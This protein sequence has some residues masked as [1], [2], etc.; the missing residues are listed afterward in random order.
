[1]R[2]RRMLLPTLLAVSGLAAATALPPGLSSS[3]TAALAPAAA[4]PKAEA[5]A[6][7]VIAPKAFHSALGDYVRHKHKQ[8]PTRL[9][10][11]EDVLRAE[12]GVDDPEKLKR[13]L[14]R[15]WRERNAGYA[16]LVGDA[17]VLPVRYMVLDRITKEAF[18]YAFYPSD[19]YYGDL[20]KPDGT[21]DDWNGRKDGFHAGYF[22]EVRGEANKKDP[23]NFDGV[24]YRPEIAVGRWPV[25]TAAEVKTVADKTVRYEEGVRTSAKPNARR[26]AFVSVGGWVDS[27]PTMDAA[28]DALGGAKWEVAKRYYTGGGRDDKTPP[29]NGAQVTQ[30]LREGAGI[31][32][33]AGHG[34]DDGWDQ[35]LSWKDFARI[36]NADRLPV[37]VSAGCSTGRFATCPPY[38]G[39][40]DVNGREHKGTNAGQVFTQPPPPPAPYQKGA[41]NPTGLGEQL[42]RAGAGGA[43]AYIGC[44]TGSQPAGLTLVEGLAAAAAKAPL[45][46]QSLRLGD[47]WVQ[48]VRH[49]H[50][51]EKLATLVPTADWYPASIY[52]QAMKFMLFGDPTLLLPSGEAAP[53]QQEAKAP[54]AEG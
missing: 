40:V 51:K 27:R 45:P 5:R 21:F 22:G 15:E 2:I 52:F 34:T 10:A 11:L 37:L 19:L 1:V 48:A 24:D 8:L 9:V 18:D 3:A 33:H 4:Q 25:S 49:Y 44:N 17:D 23:I 7:L 32:F 42:L 16:L 14:H 31:I 20:A 6:F 28:S 38:E 47:C 53:P 54:R 43:V 12:K 35:C 41:H 50:E 26:A 13:F 39:Y 36:E 46:G 29:P 30:L